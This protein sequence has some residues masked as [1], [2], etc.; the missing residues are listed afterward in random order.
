MVVIATII[1]FLL[2]C[3]MAILVSAYY[4]K[5]TQ[6]EHVIKRSEAPVFSNQQHVKI[7]C[8]N[9]QFMAGKDYV[10]WFDVPDANGPDSSPTA[11]AI[12]TTI[13][14][15]ANVIVDEDPD[16]IFL[17][18]VDDGAKRTHNKDQLHALLKQLPETY[19]YHTSAFYWKSGFVPH[20]RVLGRT[21]MK[22]SIVSKHPISTAKRY[23]LAL[24]PDNV[25]TKHLG[26]K[27]A[28]LEAHIPFKEGGE[29]VLLN[30]HLEAFSKQS[31]TLQKQVMQVN[32]LLTQ[33]D[34]AST[35]WIIGGDFN[36]LPPGQFSNLTVK[37]QGYYRPQSEIAALTDKHRCIPSINDLRNEPDK[38]FTFNSNDPDVTEPD[39]TL[40]Y[41]FYSANLKC[42]TKT[43]R[44]HD[45]LTISDHFPIIASFNLST[46]TEQPVSQKE[47]KMSVDI[48]LNLQVSAE[49]RE[50][51][52]SVFTAILPDTRAY[53][54]CQ[55]VVVT[56]NED[57]LH[58][59]VL[60][61]KWDSRAEY[62]GYLAWRTERGDMEK[63]A[64]LLSEPP[65]IT[66]LAT[67]PS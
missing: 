30:T 25:I 14:A 56:S 33:L 37:Q 8:Y 5:S 36:L 48:I 62:E 11:N 53:K 7:L 23:Q 34:S 17:Q 1:A 2:L 49:N 18:E 51:L 41:L 22:L 15:V 43:V 38:W 10:F 3:M 61:E 50:E 39:R 57:D 19:A 45:T 64:A 4:P 16:F 29:L 60:L 6:A 12:N 42:I 47:K 58:N 52:L 65:S 26:I 63:L 46:Y 54:G 31:D 67:I 59:I 66:Y 13:T 35:P 44:Q 27:R 55:S 20:P 21:G 9:V 28:I 40:D 32:E 24:T